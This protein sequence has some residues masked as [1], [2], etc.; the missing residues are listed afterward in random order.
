MYLHYCGFAID[1]KYRA[2]QVH[3]WVRVQGVTDVSKMNNIPKKLKTDLE[4]F[5]AVGSLSLDIEQVSKDGTKK[6][7]CKMFLVV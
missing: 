7:A 6:R 5:A 1:P 3:N 4:R 2:K